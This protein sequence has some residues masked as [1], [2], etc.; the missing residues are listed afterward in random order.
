M[1]RARIFHIIESALSILLPM[2]RFA[3]APLTPQSLILRVRGC[4]EFVHHA[5]AGGNRGG[6]RDE[7]SQFSAPAV[8][9]MCLKAS[10]ST[11]HDN[12]DLT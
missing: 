1:I 4:H 7:P 9:N 8:E 5:G 6:S 11:I 2:P 3:A 12:D 10:N